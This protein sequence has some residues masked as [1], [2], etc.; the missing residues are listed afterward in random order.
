MFR[1]LRKILGKGPA[2]TVDLATADVPT[3]AALAASEGTPGAVLDYL[4][5]DEDASVRRAVAINR[6]TPVASAALLAGDRSADVRLALAARLVSL[7]PDLS[8]EKHSELYAYA[9]QALG[10]LAQDEVLNIRKAL[11]TAL[12]D[13]AHAPPKVAGQ[14]ARDLERDV[15][16]PI[17]RFC[18]ALADEDLLDILS[19]HPAPWAVKAVANRPKVSE[20]V[21]D[22]VIGTGDVEAGADLMN[23]ANAALSAETLK[24]I[25]EKAR[26][27]AAWHAPAASRKELSAGL[28]MQLAGF[29]NESVL[30]V[31]AKRADFDEATKREVA[32]LVGRRLAFK[33]GAPAETA[34]EKV[35]RY[36]RTNA[37]NSEVISDA[38]AWQDTEFVT[39][40]LAALAKIHPVVAAKML[41]SG[42]AKPVITLCWKAGM[43]MRLAVDLQR[44]FSKL[45][46]KEMMYA[47]GG[48]DYPLSAEEIKWQLEF[49]GIN[50]GK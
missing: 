9:V 50:S 15:S 32:A 41:K 25:V 34:H 37:L 7:L 20:A 2:Q 40:A 8:V 13:H 16:E 6:A 48:S 27:C 45:G 39:L 22:A 49:F 33:G 10:V 1:F 29:V 24:R 12:K 42:S 5:K 21:A 28:A 26:D 17:L 35:A 38:L 19:T 43:P 23:N 4:S 14:L 46:P 30:S 31:L 36:L 3:R 11:S 47:R 18:V 44:D